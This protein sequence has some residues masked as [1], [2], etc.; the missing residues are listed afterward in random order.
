MRGLLRLA[1]QASRDALDLEFST[2]LADAFARGSWVAVVSLARID[3]DARSRAT[4]AI[5]EATMAL[6]SGSLDDAAAPWPTRR[7]HDSALGPEGRTGW[8]ALAAAEAAYRAR[9]RTRAGGL[10]AS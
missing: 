3:E 7:L 9:Y 4:A 5:V 6:Y 2:F 1:G 10:D 8:N